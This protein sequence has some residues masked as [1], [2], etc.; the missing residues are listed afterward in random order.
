MS[1]V[2]K[3]YLLPYYCKVGPV[4]R[5]DYWRDRSARDEESQSIVVARIRN[6]NDN[7]A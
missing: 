4:G 5:S 7:D 1:T 6:P 2:E 3:K